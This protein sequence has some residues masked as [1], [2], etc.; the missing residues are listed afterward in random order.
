[1]SLK[2]RQP[3]CLTVPDMPRILSDVKKLGLGL[4]ADVRLKLTSEP[5]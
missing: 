5:Y 1:M 2:A 3:A 4:V